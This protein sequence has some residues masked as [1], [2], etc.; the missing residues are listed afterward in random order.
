MLD[1]VSLDSGVFAKFVYNEI[2]GEGACPS[3]MCIYGSDRHSLKVISYNILKTFLR[4]VL[5]R[6]FQR[7]IVSVLKMFQIFECPG[8]G[9]GVL[10]LWE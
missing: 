9:G 2:A 6:V 5:A 1:F 10:N 4:N 8:F 3:A 7:G